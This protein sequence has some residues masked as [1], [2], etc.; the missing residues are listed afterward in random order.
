MT[1]KETQAIE[2]AVEALS[3]LSP[4]QQGWA[5]MALEDAHEKFG[6]LCGFRPGPNEDARDLVF[7]QYIGYRHE[8][9]PARMKSALKALAQR[10]KAR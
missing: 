5:I 10:N 7:N 8:S 3:R 6:R 4:V 2:D 9:S 1:E